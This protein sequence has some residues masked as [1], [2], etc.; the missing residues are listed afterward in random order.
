MNASIFAKLRMLSKL[1]LLFKL[2]ST[3][4][5]IYSDCEFKRRGGG[6]GEGVNES[7]RVVFT[8]A[9]LAKELLKEH[10]CVIQLNMF[11]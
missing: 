2:V 7:A 8:P 11:V 6:E 10:S 5:V 4:V 3:S 9:F 1:L